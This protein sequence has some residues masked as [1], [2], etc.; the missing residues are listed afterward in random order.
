MGDDSEDD[1]PQTNKEKSTVEPRL[2]EE[3]CRKQSKELRQFNIY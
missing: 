3:I 2:F 1:I